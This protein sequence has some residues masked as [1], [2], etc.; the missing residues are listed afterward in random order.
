MGTPAFLPPETILGR[1]PDARADLYSLG[2][3]A[4]WLLTGRMVFEGDT[5]QKVVQQHVHDAPLPPSECVENAIPPALDALVLRCLSKDPADRPADAAELA[6][7]LT[8]IETDRP[9][10]PKRATT[11][12]E[13]HRPAPDPG[14]STPSRPNPPATTDAS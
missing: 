5:L 3:V 6:T 4:F 1:V 10:T 13:L 9:W 14:P 8:A 11:W 12:W 7:A 2:G